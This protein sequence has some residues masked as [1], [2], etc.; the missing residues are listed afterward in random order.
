[1]FEH[2][3]STILALSGGLVGLV[4]LHGEVS[5]II[6]P[7]NKSNLDGWHTLGSAEWRPQNSAIFASAKNGSAG[8][9]VLDKGYED[10]IL[11]LTFQC[12]SCAAGV[13]LRNTPVDDGHS[14]GLY[15]PIAGA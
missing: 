9:L 2:L 5:T 3:R 7:F 11:K 1:M 4:G 13:L 6:H 8:W 12:S 15:V 14:T 10:V